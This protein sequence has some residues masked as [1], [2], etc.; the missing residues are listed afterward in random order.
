MDGK[1]RDAT[2][3]AGDENE[4]ETGC[5]HDEKGGYD[6]D[7]QDDEDCR[8]KS[9]AS[10]GGAEARDSDPGECSCE[11]DIGH[12]DNDDGDGKMVMMKTVARF[13]CWASTLLLLPPQT[14]LVL[15]T[16]SIAPISPT[17]RVSA[18]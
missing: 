15:E 12:H 10:S 8:L 17:L 5:V 9:R 14:V 11:E 18:P 7:V 6:E 3:A 13:G 4:K 1:D 2:Y 16:T